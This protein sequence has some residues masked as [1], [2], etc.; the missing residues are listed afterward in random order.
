M[1]VSTAGAAELEAAA[2][3]FPSEPRSVAPEVAGRGLST[4]VKWAYATGGTADILGHWLYF[5]LA[6]PVYSSYFHLSPTQIGN[7]KA[8]TLI[9]DAFAG[10]LFGWLSDNTRSRWGRRRP[11]ILI[12]SLI[13]GLCLPLLFLPSKSW[14]TDQIFAYMLLSAVL[15]APLIASYNSAY[16]ALGAELTPDYHERANVMGYKAIVQKTVG[17]LIGAAVWLS[18]LPLFR[19]PVSGEIDS[20]KGAMAACTLAGLL[21]VTSGIINAR[22]VPER[23][24]ETAMRQRRVG[25]IETLRSTLSCKP[26]LVL[27]GVGFLYAIP[28]FAVD[29][30]GYYAGYYYVLRDFHETHSAYGM[31][32]VLKLW[33]GI[34]YTLC[35]IAAVYPAQALVRRRGKRGAL[36]LILAFGV[37]AFGLTWLMYTPKAPWL[38]VIHTGLSGFCAT[39]LWVVLPSMTA[40]SLDYEEQR[41]GARREGAF[42][43]SFFWATK[44]GMGIAS[45]VAGQA[46][47]RLTGF[48]AELGGQQSAET[49]FMIRA[50]FAGIPIVAC[51][52]ALAL[53][54]LYPLSAGRMRDIRGEL[55]ARRGAV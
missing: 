35:G 5:N 37:V 22:F 6:D 49:Y 48:R 31:W 13:S 7:V 43:S 14:G 23:Y 11:Y 28:T 54:R 55:E 12:G 3:A 4:R 47:D 52:A 41:S 45:V 26:F 42:S 29:P 34:L 40:D 16:Q 17:I 53:L 50:L 20:G 1:A 44:A 2:G 10:V 33:G 19:D 8:A 51:L 25:V 15:Y 30:L 32:G 27:L 18:G 36:S 9:A 46:L 21:M 38:V 24:Y 39:G